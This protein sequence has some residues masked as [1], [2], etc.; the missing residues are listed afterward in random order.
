MV[1]DGKGLV[2]VGTD[3]GYLPAA[4]AER[5]YRGLLYASDIHAAPLASARKTAREA[6]VE[7]RIRFLLCDGLDDCPPDA[8]DTI[9][10][11]G[12]GGDLTYDW[13][14]GEL[15]PDPE[16]VPDGPPSDLRLGV[17]LVGHFEPDDWES[18]SILPPRPPA[19]AAAT[20]DTP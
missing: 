12:M 17:R 16:S 11:A 19:G 3:H 18:V 20:R 13:A 14:T 8:V 7:E 15:R 2:D 10:I 1:C 5:G 6:G 9:V 4:L